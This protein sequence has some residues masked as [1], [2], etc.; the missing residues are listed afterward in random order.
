M[1]IVSFD[2]FVAE[3]YSLECDSLVCGTENAT[4]RMNEDPV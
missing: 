2:N 4:A 1:E 3:D